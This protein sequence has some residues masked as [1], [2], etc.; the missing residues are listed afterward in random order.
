MPA[1]DAVVIGAGP[2]GN[3]AA[4]TLA[5]G[6]AKVL[7]VERGKAPGEKNLMGGVIYSSSLSPI[8][9]NFWQSAPLERPVTEQNYWVTDGGS[10]AKFGFADSAFAESEDGPANA[11]TVL[12]APFDKWMAGEAKKAGAMLLPATVVTD[13]LMEEGRVVGVA[14]DRPNGEIPAKIVISGEGVNAFASWKAGFGKRPDPSEVALVVK[15]VIELPQGVLEARFGVGAGEGKTFE[16]FGD[17]TQGCLGYAFLYTNKNTVSVGV[18][19]LVTDFAD[20]KLASYELLENVK[21]HSVVRP[22]LEGGKTLEYGGH[23]IPEGGYTS[24]PP[25]VSDGF[26]MTGDAALMVNAVHR[27]GSNFAFASGRMAGEAALEAIASDDLSA[28]GLSGYR[29]RLEDSFILKDLKSYEGVFPFFRSRRDIMEDYPAIM[30]DALRSL[31]TVD[32]TAKGQKKKD[33]VKAVF[34]AKRPL[35]LLSDLYKMWRVLG[36]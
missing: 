30:T 18:G 11:Y 15:E 5:K 13:L 28:K 3:A 35:A 17:I 32:G 16:I 23:L 10:V 21:N 25:L 29:T 1:F 20:L 34:K 14:T 7:Q 22:L 36:K 27:E 33:L 24:L 19:G 26:L 6:G 12:R 4:I 2:A 8:V 9:P 31:F